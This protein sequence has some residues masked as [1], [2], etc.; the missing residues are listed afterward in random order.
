MSSMSTA[1][2]ATMKDLG[3][4]AR[5]LKP[6]STKVPNSKH[7][8]AAQSRGLRLACEANDWGPDL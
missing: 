3:Q 1:G 8:R 7:T 6:A 4:A 5:S 2:K